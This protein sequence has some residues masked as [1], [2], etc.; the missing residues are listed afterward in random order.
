VIEQLALE[1]RFT[2]VTWIVELDT[3]TVPPGH[4]VVV[5]P[6]LDPV[7]DG[8]DHPE[9][10]GTASVTS[11]AVMV[12]VAVYVNVNVFPDELTTAWLGETVIVPVPSLPTTT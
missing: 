12:L 8:A 6:A 1:D 11:P 7:V 3:P 5:N 2:P 9:A 10:V 4:V